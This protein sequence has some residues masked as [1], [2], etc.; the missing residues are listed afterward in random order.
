MW[1]V[2][3]RRSVVDR[4]QA[5]PVAAVSR[6]SALPSSVTRVLRR[7]APGDG[8]LPAATWTPIPAV[9][10]RRA[11]S[12]ARRETLAPRRWRW[13]TAGTP[14]VRRHPW[15]RAVSRRRAT[16]AAHRE[17]PAPRRWTVAADGPRRTATTTTPTARTSPCTESTGVGTPAARRATPAPSRRWTAA[18]D[19]PRRA[20]TATTTAAGTAPCAAPH[21]AGRPPSSRPRSR[22]LIGQGTRQAGV[23]R[24]A[25]VVAAARRGSGKTAVT[26]DVMVTVTAAAWNDRPRRGRAVHAAPRTGT[27][28]LSRGSRFLFLIIC[29]SN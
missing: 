11:T 1:T 29:L 14:V 4:P 16:S 22:A 12:A 20:T 24:P 17:T 26:R 27:A 18:A 8:A 6:S 21:P 25:F 19:G 15:T 23:R 10:H 7:R 5:R 28:T 3:R 2:Y 13:T 9:R